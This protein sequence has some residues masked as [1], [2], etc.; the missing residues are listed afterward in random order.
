MEWGAALFFA[1]SENGEDTT[2]PDFGPTLNAPTP[3]LPLDCAFF[4]C[5]LRL[6]LTSIIILVNHFT[7]Y[8]AF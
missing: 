7:K 8:I 4:P 3:L 1:S 6:W 2:V 5:N